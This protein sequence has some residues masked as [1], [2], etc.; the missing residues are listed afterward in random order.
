MILVNEG[1]FTVT[2][3]MQ[4]TRSRR[5]EAANKHTPGAESH[6]H[7]KGSPG[8]AVHAG[9]EGY[10]TKASIWHR[11]VRLQ[12]LRAW[13]HLQT[14]MCAEHGDVAKTLETILCCERSSQR[15]SVSTRSRLCQLRSRPHHSA[16]GAPAHSPSWQGHVFIQTC[17]PVIHRNPITPFLLCP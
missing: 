3:Q 17:W 15:W 9:T 5:P 4:P 2:M 8:V 12:S 11:G 1:A 10:E 7:P 13:R 6:I 14:C 16:A